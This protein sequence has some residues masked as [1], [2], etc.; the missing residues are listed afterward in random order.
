M[1]ILGIASPLCF[2]VQ[3]ESDWGAPTLTSTLPDIE[4]SSHFSL[5]CLVNIPN[6]HDNGDPNDDDVAAVPEFITITYPKTNM[7]ITV[8]TGVAHPTA[9]QCEESLLLIPHSLADANG[10]SDVAFDYGYSSAAYNI[11]QRMRIQCD[12]DNGGV[13]PPS[14]RLTVHFDPVTQL[15]LTVFSCTYGVYK[16]GDG[17]IFRFGVQ[18]SDARDR[19]QIIHKPV[20]T[21]Y[22]IKVMPVQTYVSLDPDTLSL[23]LYMKAYRRTQLDRC[24]TVSVDQPYAPVVFRYGSVP[25]ACVQHSVASHHSCS[26]KNVTQLAFSKIDL[27]NRVTNTTH[28]SAVYFDKNKCNNAFRQKTFGC[29][30]RDIETDL[31]FTLRDHATCM[32]FDGVFSAHILKQ[33]IRTSVGEIPHVVWTLGNLMHVGVQRMDACDALGTKTCNNYHLPSAETYQFATDRILLQVPSAAD[34]R[35]FPIFPDKYTFFIHGIGVINAGM[36]SMCPDA[37]YLVDTYSKF[38]TALNVYKRFT[39]KWTEYENYKTGEMSPAKVH[40]MCPSD[41]RLMY[42]AS[43]SCQDSKDIGRRSFCGK[44]GGEYKWRIID[45]RGSEVITVIQKG[46]QTTANIHFMTCMAHYYY[47]FDDARSTPLQQIMLMQDTKDHVVGDIHFKYPYQ[48]LPN[49]CPAHSNFRDIFN[50][51]QSDYIHGGVDNAEGE[52][53]NDLGASITEVN[54]TVQPTVIMK[55]AIEKLTRV[56]EERFTVAVKSFDTQIPIPIERILQHTSTCPCGRAPSFC[57]TNGYRKSDLAMEHVSLKS[58]ASMSARQTYGAEQLVIYADALGSTA[59]CDTLSNIAVNTLCVIPQTPQTLLRIHTYRSLLPKPII[60]IEMK[61]QYPSTHVE[62][63]CMNVPH[64]CHATGSITQIVLYADDRITYITKTQHLY[65]LCTKTGM[66]PKDCNP[67]LT[68]DIASSKDTPLVYVNKKRKNMIDVTIDRIFLTNHTEM[69]CFYSG[70]Y[71]SSP[72]YNIQGQLQTA[73]ELCGKDD[74]RVSFVRSSATTISM[75]VAHNAHKKCIMPH[76][77]MDVAN[78]T[79]RYDCVTTNNLVQYVHGVHAKHL[80]LD[81]AKQ[82]TQDAYWCRRHVNLINTNTVLTSLSVTRRHPWLESDE[83][84]A[85]FSRGASIA[86][87]TVNITVATMKK[88]CSPIPNV[89]IPVLSGRDVKPESA[90]TPRTFVANVTCSMPPYVSENPCTEIESL[91]PDTPHANIYHMFML[92]THEFITKAVVVDIAMR[93]TI[94]GKTLCHTVGPG[95]SAVSDIICEVYQLPDTDLFTVHIPLRLFLPY[96]PLGLANNNLP[97]VAFLCTQGHGE[98][99]SKSNIMKGGSNSMEL[100]MEYARIQGL[101][102]PVT[103]K[104]YWTFS[105]YV[106]PRIPTYEEATSSRTAV[107]ITTVTCVALVLSVIIGIVVYTLV[108]KKK[109]RETAEAQILLTPTYIANTTL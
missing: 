33:M 100:T 64:R 75:L 27:Y 57:G 22:D 52:A 11:K 105:Q 6:T 78:T 5:T 18:S 76:L 96:V 32:S 37:D 54:I 102:G 97:E 65:T 20:T 86:G 7:S 109:K 108:Q 46:R 53:S 104:N 10:M 4:K 28:V 29:Y 56:L 16:Y 44:P 3:Q 83:I 15:E 107:L 72:R 80:S 24:R 77:Y 73:Q 19:Y 48:F 14:R 2:A 93:Y 38:V 63:A 82:E 12:Y 101:S 74:Y 84:H 60:A 71:V 8:S 23:R 25:D 95:Q 87:A 17:N 31:K 61:S 40:L 45:V 43:G 50:P 85:G 88:G 59:I 58:L 36:Q 30:H 81:S 9:G 91:S 49:N 79:N 66:N 99:A 67:I 1:V 41:G 55:S 89:F 42:M 21:P 26:E 103:H 69:A 47:C 35:C 94:S 92:V 98:L 13:G 106:T 90:L 39:V 34:Y 51:T 62:L 68:S 70:S